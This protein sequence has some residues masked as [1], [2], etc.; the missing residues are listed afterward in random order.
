MNSSSQLG[1]DLFHDAAKVCHVVNCEVGQ[2][3]A[4]DL[5]GYLL[6]AVGELAVV[7]AQLT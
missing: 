1:L 7:Q 5:G 4:V 3:V 6:Q 2:D